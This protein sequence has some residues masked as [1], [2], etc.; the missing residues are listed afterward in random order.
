MAEEPARSFVALNKTS[1]GNKRKIK[2]D[3][4]RH[5]A[6]LMYSPFH[7]AKS[8][9]VNEIWVIKRSIMQRIP[10]MRSVRV[11][12]WKFRWNSSRAERVRKNSRDFIPFYTS[13]RFSHLV[14]HRFIKYDKWCNLS[15]WIMLT[16]AIPKETGWNE[17]LTSLLPMCSVRA[18]DELISV[19]RISV[20]LERST[21][22]LIHKNCFLLH[23]LY[24]LCFVRICTSLSTRGV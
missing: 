24:N 10:A 5:W 2:N 15:R 6:P 23:A 9:R 12:F 4:P 18:F 3:T 14:R 8:S 7:V 21:S 19:S 11:R 22:R 16:A 20:S 17:S 13:S 1:G